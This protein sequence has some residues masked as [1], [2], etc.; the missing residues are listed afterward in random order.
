MYYFTGTADEALAEWERTKDDRLAG[1]QPRAKDDRAASVADVVNAFLA[2]K[3]RTKVAPR[4][5]ARYEA[6][7]KMLAAFWGRDRTVESIGPDDFQNLRA[8]M[9]ERWGAIALGNEIQIVRSIFVY[10]FKNE[11]LTKPARYGDNFQKPTAKAVREARNAKGPKLFTPEQIKALLKLASPNLKAMIHLGIN[12]ALG[13]TD[14]GLLPVTAIDLAGGWL[15]Y[16][17]S[18]T[19]MPRRIPL[20]P[21]TVAA[22]KVAIEKR[23]EPADPN[24]A[25]LLFVAAGGQNYIGT[26]DG[27]RVGDEFRR[28]REAVGDEV[29]GRSFYD[30]RRTF[31]T[32]AD[33]SLDPVAIRAIMGHVP[34]S[35]DMSAIYRQSIDDTRLRA[36]A[37]GVRHWLFPDEP[38]KVDAGPVP[39]KRPAAKPRVEQH[40][41]PAADGGPQLRVVG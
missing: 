19:G 32:I 14:L 20:W 29:A 15:D 5:F 7:G 4:T 26:H 17:R 39:K 38:V 18:K 3:E 24:D 1:R 28:L 30:L 34:A 31:Q 36:V 22:V 25:K 2:F 9:A 6:T 10:G 41:K 27:C 21:E 33:R 23:P 11:L 35:N 8:K 16:P 13:N 40:R 12:A 37:D